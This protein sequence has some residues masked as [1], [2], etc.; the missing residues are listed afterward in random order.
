MELYRVIR[1]N[2]ERLYRRLSH[3][4]RDAETYYRWR[5][6]RPEDLDIETRAL[7][8]LYLNRNCFNGIYRTNN[9]GAFNVPFGRPPIAYLTK[10]ELLLCSARLTGAKLVASDFAQT[11]KLVRNG[12]FVYMDPPFA[13]Q[14]RRV[15]R[16]YGKGSF[17]TEDV[18]RLALELPR[19]DRL[20]A[21]FC[22]S[23][24]DCKQA[25]KLAREWNSIRFA[26]RRNVAG[27]VDDRRNAYEWLISN[28]PIPDAVRRPS[29]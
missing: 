26:I 4:P 5:R 6:V 22:V 25:R 17:G 28:L 19:L 15:F 2:P 11:L 27:F 12:D 3:I 13:V 1:D 24:A 8:F 10:A 18:P 23:Y 16:E 7:R 29:P 20:G 21:H 9:A 14:S